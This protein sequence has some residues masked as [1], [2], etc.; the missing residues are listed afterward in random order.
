MFLPIGAILAFRRPSALFVTY[1]VVAL[2]VFKNPAALPGIAMGGGERGN[3]FLQDILLVL[4]LIVCF[5]WSRIDRRRSWRS[6][7]SVFLLVMLAWVSFSALYGL[8]VYKYEI[9]GTLNALKLYIGYLIFFVPLTLVSSREDLERLIKIF[10]YCSI[11]F[12]SAYVIFSLLGFEVLSKL[13]LLGVDRLFPI[14]A[15]SEESPEIRLYMPATAFA[16]MMIIVASSLFLHGRFLVRWWTYGL[17]ILINGLA[18]LITFTRGDWIST[19]LILMFLC[20]IA[21]RKHKPKMAILAIIG[22][23]VLWFAIQLMG[24]LPIFHNVQAV[25]MIKNTFT[26]L[27][28][29]GVND[30]N[31]Q[32]RLLELEAALAL[33]RESPIIGLGMAAS[34]N[35]GGITTLIG[36]HMNL[37]MLLPRLGLI[38]AG[39]YLLI[40]I[41]YINRLRAAFILTSDDLFLRGIVVGIGLSGCQIVVTGFLS[42]GGLFDYRSLLFFMGMGIV[43]AVCR[44]RQQ[45]S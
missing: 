9:F 8:I 10:F 42:S 30:P 35:F 23:V 4:L 37:G 26:G 1:L 29:A 7:T 2:S 16:I 6:K 45:L 19:V 25:S 18:I 36:N 11:I 43:E 20:L 12:S 34:W 22:L 38:G 27:F 33:W 3:I 17:V 14:S 21:P 15:W 40:I 44:L 32:G 5:F 24:M 39:L 31:A 13:T 28:K 41:R